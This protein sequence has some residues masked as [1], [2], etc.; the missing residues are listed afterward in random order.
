MIG[1]LSGLGSAAAWALISTVMRSMSNRINPISVNALRCAYAAVFTIIL[2]VAFGEAPRL[3][4]IPMAGVAMIVLSGLLGQGMGDGMFV[5]SMKMIGAARA[6]PISSTQPL[7]TMV[8]AV[9]FLGERVTVQSGAGTVVVLL[10]VYLLAFP[11][12]PLSQVGRLI[13]SADRGG[14]ALAL[15]AALCW[16]VS[17][18]FLK[19]ALGEVGV[20]PTNVI[21]M[22]VAATLLFGFGATVNR[23]EVLAGVDR[24]G[25]AIMGVVGLLGT[26]SSLGYVTAVTYIGV[27]KA[28]VCVSTS[29]FFGLPLSLFVLKEKVNL[30]ILLGSLLCVSGIWLVLLG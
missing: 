28:A 10:G 2:V 6:M 14:I 15:G 30:R 17:S 4:S 20:L 22:V 19:L 5:V 9:I 21:R 29:P 7:L 27:A 3:M 16:S 12:G 1:E 23:R 11:Y 18:I 24:R 8:L 13:S 25:L 26:A